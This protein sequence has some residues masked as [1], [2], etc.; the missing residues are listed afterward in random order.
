M[1]AG[2]CSLLVARWALGAGR[3]GAGARATKAR[4]MRLRTLALT[5]EITASSIRAG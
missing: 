2:S 1:A 3:W 5:S 4:K